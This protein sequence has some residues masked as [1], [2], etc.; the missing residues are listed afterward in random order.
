MKRRVGAILV[1]NK[2]I[3]ATGYIYV[4]SE[5]VCTHIS[6]VPAI[7]VRLL[8]LRTVMKAG[9]RDVMTRISARVVSA[10]TLKRMHYWK[11]D[12]NESKGPLCTAT[13]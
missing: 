4:Y 11:L 7:M 6:F 5:S 10:Y 2:R 12:E 13:R 1:R 9:A 3:L 8:A